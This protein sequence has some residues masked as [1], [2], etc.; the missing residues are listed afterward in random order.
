MPFNSSITRKDYRNAKDLYGS[1]TKEPQEF[2]VE[3]P[4]GFYTSEYGYESIGTI[5][6]KKDDFVEKAI[7]DKNGQPI[8]DEN[9][10]PKRVVILDIQKKSE[11]NI[12][13][14]NTGE[15][16]QL[17]TDDNGKFVT[18]KALWAR[19]LRTTAG[20]GKTFIKSFLNRNP[21]NTEDTDTTTGGRKKSRRRKITKRNRSKKNKKT[22][23]RK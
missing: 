16:I 7:V 9:G 6:L 19:L 1:L 10:Q 12:Y 23:R 8:V 4:S 2:K 20:L 18:D 14:W 22:Q 21:N 13:D 11:H 5:Q 3:V 15:R 17:E